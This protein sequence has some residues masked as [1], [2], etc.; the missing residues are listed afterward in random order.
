[1]TDAHSVTAAELLQFVERA[2]QLAAEKQDI[3]D[4]QK[5]LMAELVGRGYDKKV[6]AK[7]VRDRKLKRDALAEFEAVEE[8]YR[9]A[10][11]MI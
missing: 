5:E 8:L 1:M 11:G 10:V 2:E 7:V 6:F 4:Q 3:A 9:Q